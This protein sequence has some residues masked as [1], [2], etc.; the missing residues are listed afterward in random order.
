MLESLHLQ[1]DPTVYVY[2]RE[3]AA[4]TVSLSPFSRRVE[5][6][7]ATLITTFFLCT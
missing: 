1:N 4:T 2:T 6:T 7:Q 5:I 3:G